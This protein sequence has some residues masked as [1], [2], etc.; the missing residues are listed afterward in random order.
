[1]IPALQQ[2]IE[3]EILPRYDHFDSGHR[4]DHV[5]TVIARSLA[6][7]VHYDVDIDMVYTIAAYHDTGLCA[8]RATH[9]TVSGQIVKADERL[10]QWFSPDAIELI[11]EAVEDHRA[12]LGHAPRSIYGKIVAEADRIIDADV[13]IRRTIQYG[14]ANYPQLNCEQQLERTIAHLE[15]KYAEGGYITLWLPESDNAQKLVDLRRLIADRSR[16]VDTINTIYNQLTSPM[17]HYR[18]I[19]F[20]FDYTLVDSSSGIVMCFQHVLRSNGFSSVPDDAIRRTIGKTLEESFTILT[21]ITDADTLVR[22]K[23][24]Y[25]AYADTCMTANTHFFPE[26]IDALKS[27]KSQGIRL[28][29][30]STKYRYR[31]AEFFNQ[32]IGASFFDVIIGGEDVKVAKPA[33]EGLLAAIDRLSFSFDQCLYIGDSEVDAATAQAAGVDFVGLL[34]GTTSRSALEQYPNKQII[35][36]LTDLHF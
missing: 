31:I 27:L 28:G 32:T 13:A 26:I 35:D 22:F 4:R 19:L 21:T 34:H 24:Q 36:R 25:V 15:E 20:D 3:T 6:L 12:S 14:L 1:M 30:I 23:R 18:A 16:L 17:K 8:S 9:H 11:A 10:K 2:Y 7:A 5:E 29:I 33:P